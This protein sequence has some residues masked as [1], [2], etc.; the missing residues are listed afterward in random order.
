MEKVSVTLLVEPDRDL[1]S[2]VQHVFLSNEHH[3]ISITCHCEP[4]LLL[5][6]ISDR[7]TL[8]TIKLYWHRWEKEHR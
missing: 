7:D 4:L 6:K 2:R 3:D 5:H 1:G 8:T